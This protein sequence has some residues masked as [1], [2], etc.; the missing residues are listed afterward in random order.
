MPWLV[1]VT[2]PN[3]EAVAVAQAKLQGLETWWPKRR[4]TSVRNRKR[5]TLIVSLFPRYVFVEM[6]DDWKRLANT[7]GISRLLL[8]E[9]DKP[10]LLSDQVVQE[11][12]QRCDDK[13]IYHSPNAQRFER[14]ASVCPSSGAFAGIRGA[15]VGAA[16]CKREAA[17]F[18]ILGA[19]R[20]VEFDYGNLTAA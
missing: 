19:A 13:G 16:S 1:A 8:N 9:Q 3:A 7:R 15:Y 6:S 18:E 12:R 4:C 14:G 5:I 11:L 20:V 2:K 17:L 10:K